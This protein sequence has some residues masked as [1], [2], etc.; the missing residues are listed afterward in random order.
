MN[1]SEAGTPTMLQEVDD[2]PIAW[3]NEKLA[4]DAGVVPV[5][6]ACCDELLALAT[7]LDT[8]PLPLLALR[9]DDF[10]LPE[11]RAMMDQVRNILRQGFGFVLIDRLP[12]EALKT[13]TAVALYWLLGNMVEPA[14]AQKWDGTMKYDVCDTGKKNT[15]GSGVRSSITKAGQDYFVSLLPRRGRIITSITPLTRRRIM[16][17]CYA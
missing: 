5:S 9:P 15:P 12:V 17:L 8:N 7:L 4:A 14:A 1:S 13:D 2:N 10:D 16:S 11:C 6:A 3:S